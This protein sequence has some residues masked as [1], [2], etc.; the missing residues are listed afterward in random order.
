MNRKD[1]IQ[2]MKDSVPHIVKK[3]KTA[4]RP[5][6][7]VAAI[8]ALL[9]SCASIGRI[10]GGPYDETPPVFTEGSPMPGQLNV[11]KQKITIHF[12]EFIK[13][14]KPG[15]KVVISPPQVQQPEVK[16][17]GK[18]VVITMED[19]LKANT[20]YAIDFADAIQD[21][22]EGNPLENFVYTFSTGDRLDTMAVA[23][24]VLNAMNLE[25]V[26]GI[27]VGLHANL[28][29]S[30]FTT[31]PFDRVGRTDSRGHFS[32]R[33]VAPGSYRLYA[34]QDADQNYF[35]SQ[36]SEIIAFADSLVIPSSE[37]RV[38]QDT[39][40]VDSL[41]I[42]TIVTVN[43]TYYLPDNLMLRSFKE[44][45][46]SQRFIKHERLVP[47]KFS[48][49][50]SAPADTLPT[51]RGLNFDEKDAF[52]VEDRTGRRDTLDYWIK[53]SLIYKQDSLQLELSYLKTDSLKQLV[54]AKDTITL[55]PK[56]SYAKQL[57]QKQEA[58]EEAKKEWEK[59]HKKKK[60]DKD[61]DKDKDRNKE[62]DK[63]K[64]KDK[65]ENNKE[66]KDSLSLQSSDSLSLQPS[67]SLSLQPFALS[68]LQPSDSLSKQMAD[69][70]DKEEEYQK[71]VEYFPMDVYAPGNMDVYDYVTFSFTEPVDTFTRATIHLKHKVDSIYV[72]HPFDFMQDSIDHK[73]YN[74]YA[75]WEPGESYLLEVDSLAAR[76][77]YGLMTDK[78]KKEFK[79]KKL[80]EYGQ[81][82]FNVAGVNEPA[83]VELLDASDKVLRTVQLKD[84]KADFYFLNPGKYGARL[85]IDKNQNGKWDTGRYELRLQPEEVFYYYQ[86][87][88]LK[89]NFDLTQDWDIHD[90]ALD[91][92]KPE[93]MKKQKPD[94]KKKKNRNR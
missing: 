57:K 6:M 86:L 59:K 65:E 91:K 63:D 12:D 69:K 84:G 37:P 53:D 60:R 25:P 40:W 71:P 62:K 66:A 21:N 55:L 10:E 47:N 34:L 38:R 32:I 49:F 54:P 8:I 52:I 5:W 79:A 77:I 46:F 35:Y 24:T 68:S 58:E 56:L 45:N 4:T 17:N 30:A 83:F 94:E 14:D 61:K 1:Y 2:Y 44:T 42:D 51:L 43:Y 22:N 85:V 27:Q 82:F 20:T 67:D 33:G 90:R 92:Q 74:L 70:P 93:E 26:K 19:T 80:E 64:E 13:L 41:T 36:P 3:V 9:Y 81:I 18:K 75:E 76:G 48:L 39:T 31:L 11:N 7:G 29:D 50:F 16:A 72:D 78:V 15:E 88:E 23:G 89:A 87:L 28:A 73:K